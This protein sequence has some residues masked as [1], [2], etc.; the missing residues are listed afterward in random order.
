MDTIEFN[1]K[2]MLTMLEELVNTDS[3]SYDKNGVDKVGTFLKRKYEKLNFNVM[4]KENH[5]LGNHLLISHKQA[6]DPKI[7][8]LAHMDTVFPEG[9]ATERPFTIKDGRAYGPGVIDM[10]AS[11]VMLYFAIKHL[12]E[13]K[14]SIIKNVEIILNSDEEIGTI[15]SRAL[16]EERAR[17]K[18]CVFVL[19]PAREDGSIVSSRRGV[20]EYKLQVTGKAAH[21]GI[22]PEKG[23]SAIEELAHKILELQNLSDPDENLNVN[24]GLIEG[25]TSVNTVAPVAEAS[26]DVRI[27]TS[28][29]GEWIHNKI[30]DVCSEEEV[31]GTEL[32]L[33]GGINRPPMVFTDE[34]E[35]LVNIVQKEAEKLGI[36]VEHTAT[37]GGSDASFTANMGI[38]TLDG[39]GPVGG[40]QHSQEEY[41]EI[42]SLLERTHLFINVLKRFSLD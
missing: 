1:L 23:R 35:K 12:A 31:R 41:L 37:G 4:E 34:I 19:E 26:I 7:L 29:Q 33:T 42:D 39:L 13:T 30:Q 9:T 32:K 3:G 27:S 40:K 28:K 17:D 22:E 11:H 20:G 10:K 8:I 5:E 38:P 2:N 15:S 16:I 21:S 14:S 25:G 6:I 24:V 18:R 36:H